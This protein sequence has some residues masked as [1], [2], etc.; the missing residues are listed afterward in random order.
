MI[1]GVQ[2]V[3]V[4]PPGFPLC[5]PGPYQFGPGALAISVTCFTFGA[6]ILVVPISCSRMGRCTFSVMTLH[7]FFLHWRR[8]RPER[9]SLL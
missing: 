7:P 4:L 1:L 9:P 5:V 8:G 2:E 6:F 3:N